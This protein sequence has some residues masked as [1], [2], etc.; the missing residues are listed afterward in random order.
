MKSKSA[1]DE[2]RAMESKVSHRWRGKW[3]TR[4]TELKSDED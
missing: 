3:R 1:T 2:V 4:V